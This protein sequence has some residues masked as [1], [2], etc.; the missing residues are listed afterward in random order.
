MINFESERV[1]KMDAWLRGQLPPDQAQQVRQLIDTDPAWADLRAA[2]TL[3]LAATELHIRDDLRQRMHTLRRQADWPK[4]LLWWGGAALVVALVVFFLFLK[5]EQP[6]QKSQA[7]SL[8]D[9]E[10]NPPPSTPNLPPSTPKTPSTLDPKPSTPPKPTARKSD[11][12]G[13]AVSTMRLMRGSTEVRGAS[14]GGV[15]PG[16]TSRAFYFFQKAKYDS[17]E[18]EFGRLRAY[19]ATPRPLIAEKMEVY[20][21]LSALALRGK[22]DPIARQMLQRIA[23]DSEHNFC[24]L[25]ADLLRDMEK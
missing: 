25:A 22:K 17:A 7:P 3:E 5:K 14:S 2:R 21:A 15:V 16:D 8:P 19:Y 13:M 10:K 24:R 18:V 20:E 11:G 9:S 23:A 6:P 12:E 4:R 1:E